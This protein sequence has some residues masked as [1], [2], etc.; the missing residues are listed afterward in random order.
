VADS[1]PVNILAS[2]DGQ[3]AEST[4]PH[5]LQDFD[6]LLHQ[7]TVICQILE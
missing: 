1:I 3:I 6:R 4:G 7:A 2:E 5:A